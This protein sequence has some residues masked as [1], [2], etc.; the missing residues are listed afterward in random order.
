M[1]LLTLT[2]CTTIQSFVGIKNSQF[3]TTKPTNPII[4]ERGATFCE[5]AQPIYFSKA[6]TQA[7]K[8]QIVIHD[9]IG[10]KLCGWS[11]ASPTI[12]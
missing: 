5:I 9:R 11:G 12:P 7:T 2:A 8:D 10:K 3:L 4:T 1:L 6:D